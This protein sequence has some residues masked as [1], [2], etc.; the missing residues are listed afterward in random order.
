MN[1]KRA[2]L[3]AIVIA[4]ALV[5]A[6]FAT[7]FAIPTTVSAADGP[8]II[9]NTPT[10][11]GN[12]TTGDDFVFNA[13]ITDNW[14]I[15]GVYVN[16]TADTSAEETST[17]MLLE[18]GDYYTGTITVPSDANDI[19]YHIAALNWNGDWNETS[20][21][22]VEGVVDNDA[23]TIT[24]TYE[25][26]VLANKIYKATADITDN[27]EEVNTTLISYKVKMVNGTGNVTWDNQTDIPMTTVSGYHYNITLDE[28][29]T[30]LWYEVWANDSVNNYGAINTTFDGEGPLV[31]HTEGTPTTGEDYTIEYG[32]EVN[33]YQNDTTMLW[34][35]VTARDGYMMDNTVHLTFNASTG[36]DYNATTKMYMYTI[37]LWGN[38][39]ALNYTI[40]AND[41]Q[42][43][44]TNVTYDLPVTDNDYPTNV[45]IHQDSMDVD[46]GV[47]QHFNVS[48][49][50]GDNLGRENLN[51]TWWVYGVSLYYYYFGFGPSSQEWAKGPYY[52]YVVEEDFGEMYGEEMNFTFPKGFVDYRVA[53]FVSDEAGNTLTDAIT[54]TAYQYFGLTVNDDGGDPVEGASVS[55]SADGVPFGPKKTGSDGTVF[56]YENMG[57]ANISVNVL[58]P[59]YEAF[60]KFFEYG[61]DEGNV[62]ETLTL[63]GLSE[64]TMILGPVQAVKDGE[65]YSVPNAN[66]TLSDGNDSWSGMTGLDGNA[67]IVLPFEPYGMTFTLTIT[68]P[69][70]KDW[71]NDSFVIPSFEDRADLY[72]KYEYMLEEQVYVTHEITV[73]PVEDDDGDAVEDALVTIMYNGEEWDNMTGSDG[74]AYFHLM[75]E[76][77]VDITGVTFDVEITHGDYEDYSG[78]FTGTDSGAIPLTSLYTPTYTV[79]VGPVK[80]VNNKVVEGATVTVTYTVPGDTNATEVSGTTNDNGIYEFT[81]EFDPADVTFSYTIEHDDL[82]TAITGTFTG[83]SSGAEQSDSIG[84]KTD[85]GGSNMML[86]AGVGIVV[87]IIIIVVVMMMMKKPAPAGEEFEEEEF[88]EEPL[89]EE[90][91]EPLFEEEEEFPEEEEEPL[92]EEEGEEEDLFEEEEE[93]DLFEDEEEL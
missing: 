86:Y 8:E 44:W 88:E 56:F 4:F 33:F 5:F 81:V 60:Q 43:Q 20:T 66:L 15:T 90:E 83:T 13:T 63:T 17:E 6:G 24:L 10:G 35:Q 91:E 74:N 34:Y 53:L 39:T 31:D 58:H 9:D 48:D 50:L 40:K 84:E 68:H 25:D 12:A 49:M 69:D 27:R 28:N 36:I 29:A 37:S 45:A 65:N 41:T 79:Q 61:D 21:D 46:V 23:P 54:I 11:P 76:E 26:D 51:V 3:K 42:G 2:K 72:Q 89:F 92:F 18:S 7:L 22:T 75:M 19:D 55:I 57:H 87:I 93:E 59:Q 73:G 14:A 30:W 80:D 71:V 67:A 64:W 82:D 77:E 52:G 32:V 85:T 47:E 70:Y 1:K 16:W 62:S 78:S 38:A